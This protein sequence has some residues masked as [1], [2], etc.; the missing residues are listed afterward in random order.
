FEMM[1]GDEERPRA[2][3]SS[4]QALLLEIA[5]EMDEG[6]A[7][8]GDGLRM[9]LD[10]PSPLM[11]LTRFNGVQFVL[12]VGPEPRCEMKSWG[13]ETPDHVSEWAHQSL[14]A[15]A[16]LGDKLQVGQLQQITGMSPVN[17]VALAECRKGELC[18]GFRSTLRSDEVRETMRN[19]LAKWST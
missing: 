6:A 17:H 19:I 14:K 3:F 16:S 5:Q 12:S 10:A 18:V 1:S 2:I 8:H 7:A 9:S 4:Y 11:G 15:F 13:L